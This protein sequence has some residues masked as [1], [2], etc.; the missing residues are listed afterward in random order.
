[1]L[2]EGQRIRFS[3]RSGILTVTSN[4]ELLEIDMPSSQVKPADLP[5]VFRALGETGE[6]FLSGQG[7]GNVIILLGD[8]AA[9]RAA[10]APCGAPEPYAMPPPYP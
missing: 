10:R 6:T 1:M 4:G 2:I 7:N 5:G 8:E 9:V 3:T